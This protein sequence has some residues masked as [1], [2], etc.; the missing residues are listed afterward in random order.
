MKRPPS[1]ASSKAAPHPVPC[2]RELLRAASNDCLATAAAIPESVVGISRDAAE[3]EER[4]LSVLPVGN[5][6]LNR[7]ENSPPELMENGR[8][9][10]ER[11]RTL[12][13][14]SPGPS[15]VRMRG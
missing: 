2:Q 15:P 14:T 10:E 13:V 1:P 6:R 9:L 7:P 12:R 8:D 5:Q 11:I 4:G 3:D